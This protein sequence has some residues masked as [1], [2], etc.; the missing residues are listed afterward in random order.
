MAANNWVS[1]YVVRETRTARASAPTFGWRSLCLPQ[2]APKERPCSRAFQ[3]TQMLSEGRSL[4][5][6]RQQLP[7]LRHDDCIDGMEDAIRRSDIGLLDVRPIDMHARRRYGRGQR[8][9]LKGHH[10]P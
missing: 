5:G 2:G 7:V 1:S 3:R 6:G 8:S 10:V 9:T 4:S